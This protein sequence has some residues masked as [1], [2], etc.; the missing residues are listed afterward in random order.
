MVT[1]GLEQCLAKCKYL[2]LPGLTGKIMDAHSGHYFSQ[3][4]RSLF[5]LLGRG[6]LMLG[7]DVGW[8]GKFLFLY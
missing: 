7:T 4:H 6:T 1:K 3:S 8:G 2:L 5:S